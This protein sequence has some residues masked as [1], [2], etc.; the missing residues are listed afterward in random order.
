LGTNKYFNNFNDIP[1]ERLYED[2]INECVQIYGI[3]SLYMPRKSGSSVDLLFGEDPT[4]KF[5]LA[6]PVELYVQSVDNFEGGELFSK[7]GLEVRKQARFLITNRS[8][9]RSVA[10]QNPGNFYQSP[11]SLDQ[12]DVLT[13]PREGDLIYMP[14]FKALFEIVYADEEYFFY[15]FGNSKI[16]GYSL[17]VEKFRYSNEVV[18]TGVPEIDDTVNNIVGAYAF[19]MANNYASKPYAAGEAL[20]QGPNP[21]NATANGTCISW[22]LPTL[23]LIVKDIQGTFLA[24][25]PIQG[26]NS[27]A[28]FMLVSNNL[29]QQVNPN[30]DNNADL[31][32]E[33]EEFLNFSEIDPFGDPTP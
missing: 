5:T 16:Y 22:N 25:A 2:L 9:Q 20:W 7:F 11:D 18:S 31:A 23:T 33:G 6:L 26:A 21:A 13:R 15:T 27:G 1:Q 4:S 29:L 17:V 19:I 30:I 10:A 14:N 8:F 32:A 12:L 28:Q 24:N 3:D